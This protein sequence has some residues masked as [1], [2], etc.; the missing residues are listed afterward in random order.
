M[1]GGGV[2]P[3]GLY[4]LVLTGVT[5]W[6]GFGDDHG[7]LVWGIV[8]IDIRSVVVSGDVVASDISTV[9]VLSAGIVDPV[10][11]V[12]TSSSKSDISVDGKSV[13]VDPVGSKMNDSSASSAFRLS[14]SSSDV[15]LIFI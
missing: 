4:H 14:V 12:A 5:I 9:V 13:V 3:G 11:S 8:W 6:M 7:L 10:L 1:N 15:S 2:A